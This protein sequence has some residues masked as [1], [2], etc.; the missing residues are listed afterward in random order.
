M[1]EGS[2]SVRPFRYRLRVRYEECDAQKVV[3]NARYGSYIDL[4]VIEFLRAA[5]L[6]GVMVHGA[7]DYQLVKQTIEW[8]APARFDEPLEVRVRVKQL[9]NTSFTLAVE[10]HVDGRDE[11]IATAE[12]VYVL[13]DSKTLA[14][15]P[16]PADLRETLTHAAEGVL[17]DH[18]DSTTRHEQLEPRG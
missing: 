5:G 6:A 16:L 7:Y 15:T 2:E 12:T 1:S 10:F 18:A 14:K 8:K 11:P 13:V 4:A 9:G 3:F 17:V